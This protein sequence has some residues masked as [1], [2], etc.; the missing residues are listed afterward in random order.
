MRISD[1]SSDVCSSDLWLAV[2][3]VADVDPRRG[4]IM[5]DVTVLMQAVVDGG[6]IALGKL[7]MIARDLAAGPLVTPFDITVL[8]DTRSHLVYLRGALA[9]IGRESRRERVCKSVAIS[10]VS[11]SIK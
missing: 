1:W 5:D 3:G 9:Q 7:S 6:G 10:G 11:A 2:A 8:T 4:P